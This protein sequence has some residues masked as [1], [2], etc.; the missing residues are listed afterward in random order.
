MNQFSI[1]FTFFH[2]E[3]SELSNDE[4]YFCRKCVAEAM[5]RSGFGDIGE[6]N[7]HFYNDFAIPG[8]DEYFVRENELFIS[9]FFPWPIR[10]GDI[11]VLVAEQIPALIQ[12]V[13]ERN[14][15]HFIRTS[16]Q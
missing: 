8:T 12:R 1:G 10:R 7:D 5:Q 11:R 4:Q 16:T 6:R 15:R 14:I 13:N 2:E 3:R 9:F